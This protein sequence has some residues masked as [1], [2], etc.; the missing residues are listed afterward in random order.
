MNTINI[1]DNKSY[2]H[3]I[4]LE[5][6]IAQATHSPPGLRR[7][8]LHIDHVSGISKCNATVGRFVNVAMQR[9]HLRQD[10]G[11]APQRVTR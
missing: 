2:T 1:I 6:V 3:W 9:S 10:N 11:V 8:H 4:S 7:P 5:N